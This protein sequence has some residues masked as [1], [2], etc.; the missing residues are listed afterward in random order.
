MHFSCPRSMLHIPPVWPVFM[1][2]I[3]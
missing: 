1:W 2:L 3:F